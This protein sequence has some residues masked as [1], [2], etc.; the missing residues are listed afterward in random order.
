LTVA[1]IFGRSTGIFYLQGLIEI[2]TVTMILLAF[3][4]FP[5]KF[6]HGGQIF[7]DLFTLK[8]ADRI[9]FRI[10][11]FWTFCDGLFFLSITYPIYFVGLEVHNTGQRTTNLEWSPLIFTY[12]AVIGCAVAAITCITIGVS[13][14][15]RGEKLPKQSGD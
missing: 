3:F 13:R 9:N 15:V 7:V 14:F 4:A 12:P 8:V 1:D 6:I 10:D 5:L 11:A 2:S